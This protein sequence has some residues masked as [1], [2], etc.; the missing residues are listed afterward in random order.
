V[1]GSGK[2]TNTLAAVSHAPPKPGFAASTQFVVIPAILSVL[3][4]ARKKTGTLL[5]QR[6]HIA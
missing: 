6:N 1:A 3:A 4:T 2:K 5:L